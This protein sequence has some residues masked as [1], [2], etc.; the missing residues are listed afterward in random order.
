MR[1]LSFV[2]G[3]NR[4]P[5]GLSQASK[6]AKARGSVWCV[7]L[8]EERKLI[9]TLAAFEWLIVFALTLRLFI[10]SFRVFGRLWQFSAVKC[11]IFWPQQVNLATTLG[12]YVATVLVNVNRGKLTTPKS[13]SSSANFH[14][15]QSE[16]FTPGKKY[17]LKKYLGLSNCI[18]K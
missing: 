3:R 10:V 5:D 7:H 9:V 17:L 2:I 6:I 1:L 4:L 15:S 13:A 14:T 8:I 16:R 18:E 12:G 11:K